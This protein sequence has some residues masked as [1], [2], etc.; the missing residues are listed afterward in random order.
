M[1]VSPRR[2][3]KPEAQDDLRFIVYSVR[4]F[5]TDDKNKEPIVLEVNAVAPLIGAVSIYE[6]TQLSIEECLAESMLQVM[7]SIEEQFTL[8]GISH[9]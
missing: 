8:L 4:C 7:D 3:S 5:K 2:P 9:R 6:H 1:K